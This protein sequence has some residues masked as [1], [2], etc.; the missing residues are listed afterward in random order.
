MLF[1]ASGAAIWTAPSPAER[2]S[3]AGRDGCPE[4]VAPVIWRA[5]GPGATVPPV[6]AIVP[7]RRRVAF[8]GGLHVGVETV[9]RNV[10]GAAEGGDVEPVGVP[11]AS[12]ARDRFDR[13]LPFLP[14]S[15]RGTMRYVAGTRPLFRLRDVEA[16]WSLL[17]IPLLPWLVARRH[18]VPVVH[19]ADSTP[20]QLRAFGAH[21]HH[22]GGKSAAK[23]AAREVLY[24]GFLRRVAAVHTYTQWAARSFREDYGVPAGRVHVLPPG[25][26]VAHWT[27][28]P[29]GRPART[30]P[31]LLFVGGD[32]H[33]KGGDLLLDVHRARLADRA[34]LDVVTRPGLAEPGPGVRVH[35]GLSPNDDRLRRLYREADLLVVPTRADCFSMA[36]LEALASGLPVVTC[37]VG[38]VGEVFSDGVEGLYVPPDDPAALACALD[39]LLADA[40]RRRAMGEAARALAVRRYDATANTHHLLE[41]LAAV[42]AGRASAGG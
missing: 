35:T 34:E 37:P 33:R 32:F 13:L 1:A 4:P 8:V 18:R 21:Y 14:M 38:G 7:A 31:R 36:G 15:M 19:A 40:P 23:F 10:A 26:D 6:S 9:F 16:V 3:R 20:R 27:P 11:I 29:D 28:P 39:A 41:L 24:R 42:A 25:V 30:R 17:D 5:R 12:Y 2:L 22:W